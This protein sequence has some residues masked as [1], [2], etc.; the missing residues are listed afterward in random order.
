MNNTQ[1]TT[2]ELTKKERGVLAQRRYREKLRAGAI[3][4]GSNN[5]LAKYK[6]KNNEYMKAY[7]LSKKPKITPD[8]STKPAEVKPKITPII[9]PIITPIIT[10]IIKPIIKETIAPRFNSS[11]SANSTPADIVKSKSY[12]PEAIDL[13][14]KKISVVM[15]KVLNTEPTPNIKRILKSLLLGYDIKGDLKYIKREMPFLSDKNLMPF[16]NKIRSFYPNINTFKSY[17][18]PFVNVLA[19]LDGS[20]KEHQIATRIAKDANEIYTNIRDDNEISQEDFKHLIDFSPNAINDKLNTIKYLND[21]MLFSIYT[22]LTPRRLEW[23]TVRLMK[24]DDG[25]NNILILDYE[26]PLNTRVI[27]NNYK[28]FKTFKKQELT[29]ANLSKDFL[30][31]LY[32]YIQFNNIKNEGDYLFTKN[33]KPISK[34]AFSQMISDLF[35]DAYNYNITLNFIRISYATY[36]DNFKYSN[37]DILKIANGMGHDLNTHQQYIKRFVK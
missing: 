37:K 11:I 14:I 5:D 18:I 22:L 24:N 36:H 8:V 12:S 3:I 15:S 33:N 7:R 35:S 17:L 2:Q 27:F 13:I 26:N 20:K 31:I 32:Q 10:P 9:K 30:K 6:A 29:L 21:K 23:S 19:R 25:I 28:T 34:P 4:E 1:A 16:I